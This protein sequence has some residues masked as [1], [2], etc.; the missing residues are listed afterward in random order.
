MK[1]IVRTVATAALATL[2]VTG[3]SERRPDVKFLASDL[4]FK[5]GDEH[6]VVP[7]VALR[8]PDHSFDLSGRKPERS[9]KETLK[10]EAGDPKNPMKMDKLDLIVREYQFTGEWAASI[11]ICPLLKRNWSRALCL[12][13]HRGLLRRL[14]QKFDLLDRV[15]LH[16]RNHVTVGKEREYDQLKNLVIEPGV[17][18]M[19]CDRA[20][21]FC[22]ALVEV[23]PTV[24]AVW[25][26]S[27]NPD[28]G[29]L[30]E[31]AAPM[32]GAAIA[33]FVRRG[34]GPAE[35]PTLVDAD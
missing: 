22:T 31:Q 17:T 29:E 34:L 21:P 33:Q 20:S 30:P 18:R 15:K 28:T 25:T 11:A 24:L 1:R 6:I 27:G 2:C 10:S 3:C 19:R 8:G 4:Q 5:V 32:Q 12:G 13:Q 9:L 14:P 35:D 7:A 26:V 23:L 16:L